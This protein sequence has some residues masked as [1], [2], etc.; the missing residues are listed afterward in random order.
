MEEEDGHGGDQALGGDPP[1]GSDLAAVRKLLEWKAS[2]QE[3]HWS[4]Q[5]QLNQ[6]LHQHLH[7]HLHLPQHLHQ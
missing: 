3:Q 4:V 2:K 6:L 1:E 7:M 5:M